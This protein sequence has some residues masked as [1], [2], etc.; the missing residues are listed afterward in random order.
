M[1]KSLL[2]ISIFQFHILLVLAQDNK[3]Q[4]VNQKQVVTQHAS[5]IKTNNNQCSNLHNAKK[6]KRKKHGQA[7]IHT[8]PQQDKID[9]IKNANSRLRQ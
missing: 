4:P 9:S 8:A 6:H 5:N 7:I 1:K 3:L 2:I